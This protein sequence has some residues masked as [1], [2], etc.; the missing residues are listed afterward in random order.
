MVLASD[1]GRPHAYRETISTPPSPLFKK[2][3]RIS[4]SELPSQSRKLFSD[5]VQSFQPSFVIFHFELVMRATRPINAIVLS[6]LGDFSSKRMR[7]SM[8]SDSFIA[9]HL[10][11][12]GRVR[13]RT[14]APVQQKRGQRSN[15]RTTGPE[16]DE[17]VRRNSGTVLRPRLSNY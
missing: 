9:V 5:F 11:P 17:T 10:L 7:R 2:W 8:M 4:G 1:P 12:F 16:I 13:V 15:E 14:R 6:N 3:M